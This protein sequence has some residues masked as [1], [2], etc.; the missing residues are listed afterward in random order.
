MGGKEGEGGRE[1]ERKGE[2][3]R[4]REGK[5]GGGGPGYA[6]LVGLYD[7]LGQARERWLDSDRAVGRGTARRDTARRRGGEGRTRLASRRGRHCQRPSAHRCA[8][9]VGPVPARLHVGPARRSCWTCYACWSCWNSWTGSTATSGWTD[10]LRRTVFVATSYHGDGAFLRFAFYDRK[11][12]ADTC[13]HWV[14]RAKLVRDNVEA[15]ADTD[16]PLAFNP[17]Y[18]TLDVDPCRMWDC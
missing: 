3:E 1:R 13:A 11:T 5:G 18:C 10:K 2:R 9:W 7:L 14:R 17:C 6:E 15:L 4:S 16:L 8:V 12:R